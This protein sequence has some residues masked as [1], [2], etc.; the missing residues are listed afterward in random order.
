[1]YAHDGATERHY[2]LRG[3]DPE[4]ST[5]R[6]VCLLR[7]PRTECQ[8]ACAVS[9]DTVTDCD[10]DGYYV[11]GRPKSV[12]PP[13]PIVQ[14]PDECP[15]PVCDEI[16]AAFTLFWC[17]NA[18]CLNRVRNALELLL[19]DLKIPRG[20]N[21]HTAGKR[22]RLQL[23]QR[24]ERLEAKRPKLKAICDRMMAVK[25]LGNA[26]SH[27][28]EKV[29]QKDVYDGFDILE[30]VLHDMYSDHETELAKMVAQINRRKGPRKEK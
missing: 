20:K 4:S 19:D 3:F 1:V 9:G 23:H 13:L 22:R 15:E 18:A 30:R 11:A 12:T 25:H 7:C 24:I 6:F 26:G 17:D 8:E 21:D 2:R 10:E 16:Q 29:Q 5:G 28:G 14:I 27:A